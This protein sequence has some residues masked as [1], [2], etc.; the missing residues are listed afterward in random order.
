M[1]TAQ[2]TIDKSHLLEEYL[3]MVRRI[4][5]QMLGRLPPSV[6][7]DD[8]IQ[9]G[10]LGLIEAWHR[11]NQN[12]AASFETFATRR[13]RGAMLD[14][15]RQIDWA[16]RGVRQHAKRV[17]DAIR[18]AAQR[19]GHA[20]SE[21][22]IAAELGISLT[23]Y[24]EQ[25]VQIQGCQLVYAEDFESED[26][27][28]AASRPEAAAPSDP[29][30]TLLGGEFRERLVQAISQLPTREAHVLSLYYE[31]EMNMREIADSLGVTR[32]RASQL[33]GQ[34]IA[35]LRAVLKDLI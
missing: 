25:L 21:Q 11:F 19:T 15:L 31:E 12:A 33:H 7:L 4:A 22:E 18:A 8:L 10:R 5:V 34:A 23:A 26:Q 27:L 28:A 16:P 6:E 1:Y 17:E 35:R 29:L 24:H 3:P 9:A 30:A 2:G 20:P 32:A 13:V 14:E